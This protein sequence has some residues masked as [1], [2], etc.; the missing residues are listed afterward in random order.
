[1]TIQSDEIAYLDQLYETA[2]NQSATDAERDRCQ[3]RFRDIVWQLW[4]DISATFDDDK[5]SL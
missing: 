5:H 2:N 4:P 3:R 1:M